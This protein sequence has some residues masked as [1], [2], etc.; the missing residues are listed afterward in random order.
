MARRIATNYAVTANAVLVLQSMT[1]YPSVSLLMPTPRGRLDR[2]QTARLRAL[3]DSVL[4]RL[5]QEGVSSAD[6]ILAEL[7]QLITLADDVTLDRG[8]ALYVNEHHAQLLVLPVD[9]MERAVVDPTFATR[10]LVRALH[11]TPRHVVLAL[12]AQEARLFDGQLGS[13][14]PADT[15]KFPMKARGDKHDKE[16]AE[17]FL[18]R[19]DQALGAYLRLRPTPVVLIAAEPTLSRFSQSSTNLARLAGKVVGNH[20]AT[21][22]PE[23]ADLVAPHI[24]QYLASRQD[25]ALELLEQRLGQNRAV[26]GLESVWLASRWERPEML[27]VELDFF[28]PARIS[29]DGDSLQGADDVEHPDVIDDV[30]DELVE[31]VLARGAWVALVEPGRIPDNQRVALTTRQR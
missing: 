20:I 17:A 30:I 24:E 26:L 28:F 11:R 6:R 25:E 27:A 2:D 16:P 13:L 31:Q 3:R 21:P 5:G 4:R 18:N 7:D 9:V 10:D 22:L 15:T 1:N 14:G 29:P 19:V 23:I 8:L 12:S